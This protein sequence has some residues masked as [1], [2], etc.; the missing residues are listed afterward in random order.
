MLFLEEESLDNLLSKSLKYILENGEKIH[1]KKDSN[2]EI[3]GAFLKL[4]NPRN[5]IS[6]SILR[7]ITFSPLGELLWYLRGSNELNII[8][9]YIDSYHE[10]SDD[11][12]TL[13]GSYGKRIFNDLENQ[14]VNVYNKLKERPQTKHAVIQ[15]L[16]PEDLFT[17]TEDLPCTVSL[18]FFVRN[19][20]LE[21]YVFMRSNDVIK[22]FIHDIF[23]FTFLQELMAVKLGYELGTYTHMVTSLHLYIKDIE[24]AKKY[25]KE[26]IFGTKHSMPPIPQ[27]SVDRSILEILELEEKIR[28]AKDFEQTMNL[29]MNHL[30]DFW[31]DLSI[32]LIAFKFRKSYKQ[33]DILLKHLRNQYFRRFL[34][35]R[36]IKLMM[37][38]K[39]F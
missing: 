8:K 1:S 13:Y 33:L 6:A 14:F 28:L 7:G 39:S 29:P 26:G 25:L 19:N 27:E 31:Y 22:G 36:K 23:C 17:S 37:N 18:Q 2:L 11:G 15:I 12:K 9:Y 16:S 10:Y 24:L 20:K 38:D 34:L 32:I 30:Q 5:R 3:R 21:L 35:D 4:K